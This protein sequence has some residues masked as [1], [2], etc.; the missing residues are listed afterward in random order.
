MKLNNKNQKVSSTVW[1]VAGGI[2]GAS[3]GAII[4][5]MANNNQGW[6]EWNNY[7]SIVNNYTLNNRCAS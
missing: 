2:F 7:L 3:V 5:I 4:G 6:G 1:I